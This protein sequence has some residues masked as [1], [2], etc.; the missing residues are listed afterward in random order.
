MI[1]YIAF[2]QQ[3]LNERSLLKIMKKVALTLIF[4]SLVSA[5]YAGNEVA[6][7]DE[8]MVPVEIQISTATGEIRQLRCTEDG[9][10]LV[11]VDNVIT[12]KK[13]KTAV[14]TNY[15]LFVSSYQVSTINASNNRLQTVIQNI[16]SE[17]VFFSTSATDITV[18]GLAL[19]P[20]TAWVEDDRYPGAY[21]L[22]APAGVSPQEVRVM[23][24]EK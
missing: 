18:N 20:N 23:V 16:G 3:Y 7:R 6:K 1:N 24:Y 5:L 10:Q 8:N 22:Q 19:L 11:V 21:Y 9:K 15:V 17:K 13:E 12:T 4:C 14:A 2:S